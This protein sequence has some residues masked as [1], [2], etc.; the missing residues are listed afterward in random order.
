MILA[1]ELLL[2]TNSAGHPNICFGPFA[3]K[4]KREEGFVVKR[5]SLYN[6]RTVA[7]ST[8]RSVFI[9]LNKQLGFRSRLGFTVWTENRHGLPVSG[10][11]QC[12]LLPHQL[13]NHLKTNNKHNICSSDQEAFSVPQWAVH[14]CVFTF[15]TLIVANFDISFLQSC[16]LS[17]SL[18]CSVLSHP[19][20]TR[21]FSP[22]GSR[23]Q[24]PSPLRPS[25]TH[26]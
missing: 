10:K 15:V 8:T 1:K 12:Q 17:P 2:G 5:G 11:L 6:Y 19:C 25:R 4:C 16:R 18:H 3:C 20:R 22:P 9:H 21:S 7:N 13:L 14:L 23:G 24:S 26:F